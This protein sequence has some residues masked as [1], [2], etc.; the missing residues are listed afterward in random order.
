VG[1]LEANKKANSLFSVENIV[2]GL[3]QT[4]SR[5]WR[6]SPFLWPRRAL[7]LSIERRLT[8]VATRIARLPVR[9]LPCQASAGLRECHRPVLAASN[10]GDAQSLALL[11]SHTR[12]TPWGKNRSLLVKPTRWASLDPEISKPGFE[13]AFSAAHVS[14]NTGCTCECWVM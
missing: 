14:G 2:G 12:P 4:S 13:A 9:W 8:G 11:A 5:R 7:K 1:N 6:E 3:T 10:P